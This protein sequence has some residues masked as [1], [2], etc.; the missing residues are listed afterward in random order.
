M[1]DTPALRLDGVTK[2]FGGLVAVS[3]VTFNVPERARQAVIGP[4]GAGKTTLFNLITGQLPVSSGR[5]A[6]FG[7]DITKL[8]VHRRVARG[9]ARTSQITNLFPALT[10]WNNVMLAAQ[11]LSGVKFAMLRPVARRGELGQRVE[12]ALADVG[13]A[14]KS[15]VAA[16]ELSHGEQRQLEI[17]L[18]LVS[19]PRLLLLDEPAAGLSAAER[20][21]M[22][23]LIRRLPQEL[24]LILIEHDMDLALGLV[25]WVTVLQDGHV[26]VQ[27]RPDAIRQNAK[28]QEVYLGAG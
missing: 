7:E 11:G 13:L 9:M 3:D 17:A 19:R 23:R 24:T 20:V 22:A 10:V 28:V 5:I 1:P 6:L 4:N 18:A 27:D 25:E 21:T 12:Q 26:I 8:P 15:E 16:R 2:A 14:E